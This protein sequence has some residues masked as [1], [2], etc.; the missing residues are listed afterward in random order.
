MSGWEI[1][2]QQYLANRAAVLR[3]GVG[4][5]DVVLI[6]FQPVFRAYTRDVYKLLFNS[7]LGAATGAP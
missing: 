2:G 6:G 1:G 5:G 4:S 3:V 7:I